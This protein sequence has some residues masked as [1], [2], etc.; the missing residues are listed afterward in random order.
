MIQIGD[1]VAEFAY[2]VVNATKYSLTNNG[3]VV[4]GLV[5]GKIFL[6][7]KAAS[8]RLRAVRISA[9]E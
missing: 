2:H 5:P 4:L 3:W 7:G 6:V 8:A 9:E 1:C